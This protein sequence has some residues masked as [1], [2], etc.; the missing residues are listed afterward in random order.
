MYSM[1]ML[2]VFYMIVWGIVLYGFFVLCL[3]VLVE[4]KLMKFRMLR[5]ILDV[6]FW[7]E[8]LVVRICVGF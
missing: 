3:S 2:R 1:L 5:I 7:K 6:M 8:D 4:E